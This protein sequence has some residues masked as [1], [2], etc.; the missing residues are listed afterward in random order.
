MNDI[1]L[2]PSERYNPMLYKVRLQM[3]VWW[4]VSLTLIIKGLNRYPE[5]WDE[6]FEHFCALKLWIGDGRTEHVL[7]RIENVE[8]QNKTYE[9]RI[10][11]FI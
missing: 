9:V 2:A 7:W 11:Y 5:I 10:F 1:K 4:G 8:M 3:Y 6:Y